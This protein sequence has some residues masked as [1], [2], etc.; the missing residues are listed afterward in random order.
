MRKLKLNDETKI[1][2]SKTIA[3]A[4][5]IIG[6]MMISYT[7]FDFITTDKVATIGSIKIE[8]EKSHFVQWSPYIGTAL[9]LGGVIL[10]F[11]NKKEVN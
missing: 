11:R 4:L 9:L 7:G 10:I 5:M 3:I 6:L 2:K 8:K 1:M